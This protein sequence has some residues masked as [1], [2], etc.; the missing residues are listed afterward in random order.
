MLYITEF[1]FGPETK[2]I[3]KE[4]ILTQLKDTLRKPLH[5]TPCRTNPLH[6]EEEVESKTV[7]TNVD[8]FNYPGNSQSTR[9]K[10]VGKER[11]L[12]Q[13]KDTL[14]KPLHSDPR[15]TNPLHSEE[16]VQAETVDTNVDLFDYP[17]NFQPTDTLDAAEASGESVE[18]PLFVRGEVLKALKEIPTLVQCVKELISSMNRG[19]DT[20]STSSGSS[21]SAQEMISLGNMAVQVNKTC[22]RRLNR[23]RMSLFTQELAVLLFGREVLGS[24]SLT[25]NR[26]QKER[27]NP[28]K[29]NALIDTVISEFPGT[30]QSEVR[31]V[32]RRKCN[33]ES[34]VSKKKKHCKGNFLLLLGKECESKEEICV[35]F[36]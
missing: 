4:R 11:I 16:E 15:R 24:S 14:R 35:L 32:I 29:M 7:D 26:S 10:K 25:G 28:E 23:S 30:S 3:A 8:L 17:E 33:N 21:S 20:A 5:S 13:L 9:Q 19:I 6:S 31:A 27:L 36:I 34:F 1:L 18:Q 12:T 22:F 2:K